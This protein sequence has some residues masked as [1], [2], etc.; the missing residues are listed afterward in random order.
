MEFKLLNNRKIIDVLIGD[1]QVYNE[2]RM[3]NYTG[4][5]LCELSTQFGLPVSYVWG[6]SNLSRW[7]YMRDLLVYVEKQGR[8]A[9]LLAYLFDFARFESLQ[10]AGTTEHIRETYNKIVQGALDKIN[11]ILLFSGSQLQIV[12]KQFVLTK[13]VETVVFEASKVKMVTYEYIRELPERIKDDITKKDYDSVV[14]KSRT[15]LEEVMIYIMEQMTKERYKS[16]GDLMKMY[17]EVKS[18]LNM[19]QNKDWDVRVNDLLSGIN[20]IVDAIG[21][22][23]NMNSDAHGAGVGR[24]G[25]KEREARLI[26]AS[27]VM[28]AEYLLSVYQRDRE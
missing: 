9:E 17:A 21:K 7:M 11:A 12:N 2:Y 1:T 28:V 3:P 13:A 23:R 22:M 14:T 6:G 10:L 15:L 24:I 25:I 18:L 26:A 16:N 4:P 27:S 5:E 19:T 20:K 8:T